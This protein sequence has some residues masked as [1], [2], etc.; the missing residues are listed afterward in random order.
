MDVENLIQHNRLDQL[1]GRISVSA[2][3]IRGT[4][5][6][7]ARRRQELVALFEHHKPPTI[8]FTFSV[9][10]F[11]WADL[12]KQLSHA[13][14]SSV[15]DGRAAALENPC[16]VDEFAELRVQQF[17]KYFYFFF[18]PPLLAS[19]RIWWRVE[20][21]SR[22]CL[23]VHGCVRLLDDPYLYLLGYDALRGFL[24]HSLLQHRLHHAE[25][26][27]LGNDHADLNDMSDERLQAL[28]H[29]AQDAKQRIC[30]YGDRLVSAVHIAP[31]SAHIP[32]NWSDV[33]HPCAKKWC[34]VAASATSFGK[35][36]LRSHQCV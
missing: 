16:E 9:A 32:P 30:E 33:D 12:A 22:G 26:P 17:L 27:H 31:A 15:S 8:F 5:A 14:V 2:G 1:V 35:S 19:E 11:F 7:W 18:A 28:A 21:Q 20:W 25:A 3:N 10:D 13:A 36:I 4:P 34:D 24:A 23:H 6:Y 29:E